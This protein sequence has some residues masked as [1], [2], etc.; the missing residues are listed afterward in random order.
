MKNREVRYLE[1]IGKAIVISLLIICLILATLLIA[2]KIR[3]HNDGFLIKYNLM[4]K[5][6][7]DYGLEQVKL[8]LEIT[9]LRITKNKYVELQE[10]YSVLEKDNQTILDNHE[11]NLLA[12]QTDQRYVE[13]LVSY[14]L[15]LQQIIKANG[16]IYPEYISPETVISQ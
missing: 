13:S 11:S 6:N 4:A 16:L 2:N 7:L 1:W 12:I 9:E 10:K 15:L 5:E 14:S 3:E 8:K